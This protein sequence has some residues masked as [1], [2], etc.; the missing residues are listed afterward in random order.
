MN[1][2][3]LCVPLLLFLVLWPL[4]AQQQ[5]ADGGY[6]LAGSSTSYTHG[7][8]DFLIYKLDGEGNKRWRKNYGGTDRDRGFYIC[9]VDDGGFLL[10][11]ETESYTSGEFSNSDFLVYQIDADGAKTW[12]KNLG[13]EGDERVF[14]ID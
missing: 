3:T 4:T 13:G 8:H 1:I 2:K 12:R 10:F 7:D 6:I 11:G 5:T 14:F 9:R